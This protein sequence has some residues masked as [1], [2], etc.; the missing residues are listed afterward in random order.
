M[1]ESSAICSDMTLE[2]DIPEENGFQIR[3]VSFLKEG[4]VNSVKVL[5]KFNED[6]EG[7]A[8]LVIQRYVI[9]VEEINSIMQTSFRV[10]GGF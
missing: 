4:E 10:G 8:W 5:C 2:K 7:S 3:E 1:A 9:E 6:N